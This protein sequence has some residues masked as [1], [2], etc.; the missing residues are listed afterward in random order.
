MMVCGL[1]STAQVENMGVA[2]LLAGTKLKRLPK[3]RRTVVSRMHGDTTAEA[4]RVIQ[5]GER[6]HPSMQGIAASLSDQ[7]IADIAA[8]YSQQK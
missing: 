7:D 6:K 4:P 8:F 5:K 2:I 1:A 3:F